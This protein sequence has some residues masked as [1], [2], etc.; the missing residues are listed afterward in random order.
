MNIKSLVTSALYR[1][2]LP[3][4]VV[5]KLLFFA[6]H[7]YW[8]NLREPQTFAEKIVRRKV[9]PSS[10]LPLVEFTDKLAV[11]GTVAQKIG[12][13]HLIPLVFSGESISPEQLLEM[14][15]HL[16]V[17][18]NN[19][20]NSA[21]IIDK[22]SPEKAKEVCDQIAEKLRRDFGKVS[23]QWWYSEIE[24]KVLVERMLR[25]ADGA[26]PTEYQLFV[27]RGKNEAEPQIIFSVVVGRGTDQH[28]LNY[29][30]ENG[31]EFR[32][33]NQSISSNYKNGGFQFPHPHHCQELVR[34][35]KQLSE[36]IDHV[37]VDLYVSNDQIYFGELTFSSGGG[38]IRWNPPEFDEY[39]GSLWAYQD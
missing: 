29:F 11:R 8:P 34:I 14:G 30:D 1:S 9:N 28:G 24:P 37:R 15:D 13:E 5:E 7:R 32:F 36:G 4:L 31:D 23:N 18:L 2:P 25:E 10:K 39:L 6:V 17:K 21:Q 27:F 26:V 12:E 33:Q 22:N 35:A 19:D 16:V 38:R 20:C 3:A